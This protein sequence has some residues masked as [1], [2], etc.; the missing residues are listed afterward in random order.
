MRRRRGTN[1][2]WRA[3]FE[4]PD[5]DSEMRSTCSCAKAAPTNTQ[6]RCH[7]MAPAP[8]RSLPGSDALANEAAEHAGRA[9]VVHY[10][11]LRNHIHLL[12]EAVD[13]EALSRGIQ[14]LATRLARALN[15][16]TER[17]GPAFADR[18]HARILKT[19]REVRLALAYVL[20]NARRH[21]L[22]RGR[23]RRDWVDPYS[24]G[25]AF[26]GWRDKVLAPPFAIPVSRARTW[27]LAR[28]W[29]RYGLL[30]PRA[31]PG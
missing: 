28:G 1:A 12:V 30:D 29:R 14:G 13:R 6:Q 22:V 26:D 8:I 19:P 5:A 18:Y 2:A 17:S 3:D 10:S 16:L 20:N 27:L 11:V 7:A 23:T 15:R 24:S 25:G 4:L 31:V 9:R 21:G